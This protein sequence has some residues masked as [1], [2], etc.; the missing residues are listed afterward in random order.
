MKEGKLLLLSRST[1][2]FNN[3][4]TFT[5]AIRINGGKSKLKKTKTRSP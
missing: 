3:K 2:Y 4:M 5:P 1:Y